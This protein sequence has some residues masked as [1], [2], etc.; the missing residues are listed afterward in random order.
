MRRPTTWAAL[1]SLSLLQL[2][3]APTRFQPRAIDYEL[4]QPRG[5]DER[6][7]GF[8]GRATTGAA[9][10]GAAGIDPD[11]ADNGS[12]DAAP[13]PGLRGTLVLETV[14]DSVVH[15]Y[16]PFLARLLERDLA[17]GRLQ[18]AM[19][20]FDTQL[21]ASVGGRLQGFYESTVAKAIVEQPLATGDTIYGGYAVSDRFLPD[22]YDGR[23]QDDGELLLGLR[24]PL[25][26]NRSI[27]RRRA[28]VRK[29]EIGVELAEPKILAARI[30]FV[31]VS[32]RA[33]Y[34]WVAA[35]RNLTIAR[36]LLGLAEQRQDGLA[37]AVERQFLAPIDLTDNER[38]I[39]QRRIL[40]A[41]SERSF[42]AAAL[43]LSLF[44]RDAQDRAIVP[45]EQ[46]LPDG[47]PEFGNESAELQADLRIAA[48]QRPDLYALELELERAET[49]RDLADNRT[50]PAVDLIVE[51]Q[52]SFSDGPYNDIEEF[53]F[54]VGGEL[55]LPLQ[56]R[57]AFGALEQAEARI[58]RLRLQQRFARDRI[59]NEIVDAR[60]AIVAARMQ[61]EDTQRNVTLAER[62]V[63]AEQRAFDFGRSDLLRIQ[64]REAQLA[65]A[66][67]IAIQAKLAYR[68]AFADYRASLGFNA[69]D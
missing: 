65:D 4:P 29:A 30:E 2:A 20:T 44:L 54:F 69:A 15:R 13:R 53:E 14:L 62:L 42:Q 67:V 16:P 36:E 28:L 18:Q 49:D 34:E 47:D 33:Y 21:S 19:G 8:P 41:R 39:V 17:S 46:N 55:K 68:Q 63:N 50:L 6:T 48:K 23:T 52:H 45:T 40:V 5:I 11:V 32:T 1:L 59:V 7:G 9:T 26:Q 10:T 24:L 3:C 22:Y 58:S 37:R 60:S 12:H 43:K 57:D 38:L 35:G 66:R 31:R 61:F 27:D 56:R 64:L 51:A 25:L